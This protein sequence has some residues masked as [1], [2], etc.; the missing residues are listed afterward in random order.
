MPASSPAF[1]LASTSAPRVKEEAAA[2][3]LTDEQLA[4]QMQADFEAEATRTGRSTRNG[5]A[6]AAASKKRPIKKSRKK[7]D[8]GDDDDAVK[9][10]KRKTSHTGFN[11]LHVLSPEMAEICGVPVLSRPGVTKVSLS[12]QSMLS[13]VPERISSEPLRTRFAGSLEIHQGQRPAGP[14]EAHRN[15]ARRETQGAL[16][17]P[18]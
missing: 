8:G 6:T 7:T 4:R 13:G 14:E 12:T 9:K 16:A 18:G 3:A 1:A 5:G 2:A 11:K 10:K 17:G 15:S